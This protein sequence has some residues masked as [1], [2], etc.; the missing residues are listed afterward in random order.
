MANSGQV[1]GDVATTVIG[2][3]VVNRG[4]I[5]NGGTTTVAAVQDVKNLGG[6]IGGVDTTV[7][8][9]NDIVNQS[10]TA[11]A[12]VNTGNAG[13][14][15]NAS[16]MAIQS[17][18]MIAGTGSV[19]LAAGRDV[20]IDGAAVQS[21]G[22]ATIAAGRDINVGTVALTNTQDA[23]TTDGLNGDHASL[24]RNVG[25][26]ITTGGNLQTASGGNT[27]LTD[28]T[29]QAGGDASMVAAG[30]LTVTAAK[31]SATYSSQSMG[32]GLSH[33]RDS[34]YDE[35]VQ[36]SS[37]NAGGN[38]ALAAGQGAGGNGTGNL[39]ILGSSVTTSGVNG[40]VSGAVS[41]QSAGDITVGAVTE[42]HDAQH[43]SQVNA[44]GF[45]S[46]SQTTSSSTLHET[47]AVG[48]LVSGDSVA[49]QSGE[50]LTV[51][52]S[53][54]VA[55]NDVNLAAKGNVAI[56]AA[57]SSW[58]QSSFKEE[59]TSGLMSSGGIGFTVGSKM[60]SEDDRNA[61]T[62]SVASTIGSIAGNVSITAGNQ[63]RQVG[64]NV[65]T[66]QGDVDILAKQVDIIEAR[67]SYS[68]SQESKFEQSGLT[69]ALSSPV[70]D[71]LQTVGQMAQAASQTTDPRMQALAAGASALT[72]YNSTGAFKN[73]SGLAN[74]NSLKQGAQS[75]GLSV[76]ITV[77]S[78][79]S[80]SLSTQTS[81]TGQGSTIAAGGNV[82]IVATGAGQNSNLLVQG[83]DVT[84][85]GDILLKA[86][87]QVELLASQN[88]SS[89]RSSNSS[90]SA[91][92]GVAA[93]FSNNGVAFGVTASA[94]EGRGHAN[95][96]DVSNTN[97]HVSAGNT[98]TIESGGDTTLK[99][100]VASGEQVV[101]NVGGNLNLESL[102]DTSVYDGAQQN[103]GGSVTVGYGA[104][105]SASY[106]DSHVNGN[107]AS[108]VEQTGIKAG[109]GGF[110]VNVQGNTDLKGAVIA[111]S[112]TAVDQGK[113]SLATGTLTTSDIANH[114]NY[115][116]SGM[117]LSGGYSVGLGTG[118][119]SSTTDNG[120]TWSVRNFG[121]GAQGAAAGYSDE[122]GNASS[123]T[124][125]G[126]S[127]GMVTI[128]N[129]AA[130]QAATG[131]TAAE[132]IASLNRDVTSTSGANG[133]TKNWNGQQLQQEVAANAQ[134]MAVFGQQGA[135]AASTYADQQERQAIAD[136][137]REIAEKWAEGGEYRAALQ[138]A[139][140]LLAGGVPGAVGAAAS[141]ALLPE[142]G[143]QIA[144]MN[145]SKPVTDALNTIVGTVL[146]AAV[147]GASG[148]V[149]GL[150]ETSN[151]YI[152]HSPFKSVRDMAIQENVRLT[153]QCGA[154]CTEAD[155]QRI[156][157]QV[158]TLE[159]LG[160]LA[161]IG[162]VSRLTPTQA[163]E[164]T[165]FILELL[166]VYGSIESLTQ[167]ITGKSTLTGEEVNRFW[168]VMGVV[169]LIGSTLHG[170]ELLA[171]V[172][173]DT[174]KIAKAEGVA[175]GHATNNAEILATQINNFYRD[176]ASP[177]LLTQAYNQAALNSTQNASS[178]EVIL[179]PYIAGSAS[180]YDAVA[181]AQ[182][183]TYFSMSDWS[184]VQ[185]QLG[186]ENM[187]N[188]NQAFLDQ[189]IAK[190]KSFAFT[191]DPTTVRS[192]SYTEM[193]YQY[194]QN[195]GYSFEQ[196]AG[197]VYYATKK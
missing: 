145:L 30:D 33:H 165:Q 86:D 61:G 109:N 140:G 2:N 119:A 4:V 114:S 83:S 108:V 142:I 20:D 35:S 169:P 73:L 98:L 45:L 137:D 58:D 186:A 14:Y 180:S 3:N 105:G 49:A 191:V 134:I 65:I 80:D 88:T 159:E 104:S 6:S 124:L 155:F 128:T 8:A 78:S 40:A 170:V 18:G 143:E 94:S 152:T 178:S 146:G 31:D 62:T 182:G 43:W 167:V 37:V 89:E 196:G 184:T 10:T 50:D 162:Q 75:L 27:T 113:N 172:A 131:Q 53:D 136:G 100:A 150:N 71:A 54:V 99:G 69:V 101:A 25:S 68:S 76:S 120:T 92:L 46:R 111:S 67:E 179:G 93:S 5:G 177:E 149:A 32:G 157:N 38:L 116:A 121:T 81:N 39:S 13:F 181:Q 57:T 174:L 66:P 107:Y 29:V 97:T 139:I 82:S 147:G 102:Q 84:A 51:Q 132:T 193:E 133:L 72:L 12:A 168:A 96:D 151:N 112:Q 16:G 64:S 154:D 115:D 70:L 48:S 187:W 28:T 118:T 95:G 41:L 77:G 11:R 141:S 22:D 164:L 110:Q 190:G 160:D 60:Q 117:S 7:V 21:G 26:A 59:H 56:E 91:A 79:R 52:G 192:N 158:A 23:G 74:A 125:S 123:T 24:T 183:A 189:Q 34:T 36:G 153:Q 127:G 185:S 90:S 197:G 156:D 87:N 47:D 15:S 194:L 161:A 63:Y 106:S 173:A 85:G 138:G 166:P 130:Q 144:G 163:Q 135:K 171:E 17:V 175:V 55:T 188:I 19:T 122:S 126:I 9:G 195:K 44:S 103:T 176:G 42:E 129:G 1:A 148:A